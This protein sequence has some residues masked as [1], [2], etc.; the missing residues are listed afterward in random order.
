MDELTDRAPHISK[1]LASGRSAVAVDVGNSQIKLGQFSSGLHPAGRLLEP[2]AT[3]ELP[4]EQQT[5][6]FEPTPLCAWCEQHLSSHTFWSIASVYR[7]AAASFI[8]TISAWAKQLDLDWPIRQLTYQDL[9]LTIRV[10]EPAKVGIDRLL[11]AVAA[12]RLRAPEQAAIVIDLGTA[13]TVDLIEPDGAF[14]GGAI[15]PGI[16]MAGRALADQTD[17]LPHVVLGPSETPPLP[18]GKS[19]KAAIEAGLYW[20]TIGAIGEL[21]S[22]L[23]KGLSAQPDVFVTGGA[24]RSVATA[25]DQQVPVRYVPHLVLAGIAL[26]ELSARGANND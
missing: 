24:A 17:A 18:L 19:T 2:I 10:E 6:K 23:S 9:L 12:N 22:R 15:L 14:A 16:G 5:G 11:A 4:I 21:V 20:G 1:Q 25:L 3:L 8:A 7:S 13:I 26:V